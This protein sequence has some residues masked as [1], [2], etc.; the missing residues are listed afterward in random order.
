MTQ[1]GFA[2]D[3]TVN[4]TASKIAYVAM[5]ADFIHSGHLN[6]IQKARELGEVV[7]GLLTDEAI[8]DY[9]RMPLLTYLTTK[10]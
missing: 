2:P 7:I 6:I 3:N 8:A 10:N 1:T 9:K 4:Q 5:S